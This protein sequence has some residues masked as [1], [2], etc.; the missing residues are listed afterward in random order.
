MIS[1]V[2]IT[3]LLPFALLTFSKEAWF[4]NATF[5]AKDKV[6]YG[7][8]VEKL[9]PLFKTATLLTKELVLSKYP[10]AKADLTEDGLTFR[11]EQTRNKKNY[12]ILV[13]VYQGPVEKGS[14][15][16]VLEKNKTG[17]KDILL[18]K[19]LGKMGFWILKD[20][21]NLILW[22]DCIDCGH[23]GSLEWNKKR[24]YFFEKPDEK[25]DDDAELE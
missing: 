5:E 25:E 6:I 12:Q 4:L 15:L 10:E 21:N 14:F 7:I 16:L 18:E 9:D 19:V 17:W 1:S 8:P 3:L 11:V 24:G 20:E 2:L 22:N 13:G 23:S